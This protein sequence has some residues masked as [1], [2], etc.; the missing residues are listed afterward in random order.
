MRTIRYII[1]RQLSAILSK[2]I[3]S[4]WCVWT[5]RFTYYKVWH[6]SE[7]QCKD[8]LNT[9]SDQQ[10]CF[11]NHYCFAIDLY[12]LCYSIIS[13]CGYWNSNTLDAIIQ[14]GTRL[15]NT[16]QSEH[17][18]ASIYI[19]NSV[20]IF[21]IKINLDVEKLSHRK[22]TK[23]PE[24]QISLKTLI[25]RNNGKTEFLMCISSYC[26]ACS[27]QQNTTVRLFSLLTWRW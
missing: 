11:K 14:N 21:G 20:T 8:V 9:P 13:L 22:L 16:M 18:L 7:Q 15:N 2:F 6:H 27:Y 19:R 1:C 12:S 4:N 26:A 24:S 10:N 25:L 17:H 23:L 3:R 5:K